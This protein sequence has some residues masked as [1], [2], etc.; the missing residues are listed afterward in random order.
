MDRWRSRPMTMIVPTG[1]ARAKRCVGARCANRRPRSPRRGCNGSF[2]LPLGSGCPSDPDALAA[3]PVARAS[4][5]GRRAVAAWQ[6]CPTAAALPPPCALDTGT[7]LPHVG[8]ARVGLSRV[9]DRAPISTRPARGG[10]RRPRVLAELRATS[11]SPTYPAR[12][13]RADPPAPALAPPPES[14]PLRRANAQ[15][16]R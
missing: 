3:S 2:N 10:A 11:P 6:C 4:P 8:S 9:S 13:T 7:W 1:P 16:P 5:Q 15:S 14:C 12:N